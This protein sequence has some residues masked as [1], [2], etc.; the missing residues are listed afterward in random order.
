MSY[1]VFDTETLRWSDEVPGGF[2]NIA[3]FGLSVCVAYIVGDDKEQCLY[4]IPDDRVRRLIE[5]Q[6]NRVVSQS[7]LQANFDAADRIISFNADG[8]DF[9]VMES[10][11]FDVDSWYDKSLDL[12][13]RFSAAAGHRI[14]LDNLAY[15][16][17]RKQKSL[18][19]EL[20]VDY[21]RGGLE[22]LNG[23]TI[24]LHEGYSP[25]YSNIACE[26]AARHLFST[27][28]DYCKLDVSLTHHIYNVLRGDGRVVYED[29]NGGTKDVILKVE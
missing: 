20:A 6:Y 14:S 5:L 3:E 21:W 9:E 1:I 12:L 4:Y 23:W 25:A 11:G 10:A 17:L 19:G 16:V 29:R 22:L 26:R 27:V 2:E 7:A 28:I 18:S 8:F 13:T 15:A 24:G